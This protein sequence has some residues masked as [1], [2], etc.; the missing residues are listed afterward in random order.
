MSLDQVTQPF[1]AKA[2]HGAQY[3]EYSL[4]IWLIFI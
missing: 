2:N 4:T 3:Q 1:D